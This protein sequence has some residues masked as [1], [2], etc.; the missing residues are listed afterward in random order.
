M[1]MF[2]RKASSSCCVWTPLVGFLG[3]LPYSCY[4]YVFKFPDASSRPWMSLSDSLISVPRCREGG[5]ISCVRMG[6][7]WLDLGGLALRHTQRSPPCQGEAKRAAFIT[8]A[9]AEEN[10]DKWYYHAHSQVSS[11]LAAHL[12]VLALSLSRPTMTVQMVN[13]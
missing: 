13:I 1:S 11:S 12:A 5:S 7:E 9:A 10:I 4:P 8:S 2:L 3:L 6:R